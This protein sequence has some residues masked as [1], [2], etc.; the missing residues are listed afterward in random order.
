MRWR[1]LLPLAA[2]ATAAATATAGARRPSIKACCPALFVRAP[3]ISHRAFG[4]D[5][6]SSGKMSKRRPREPESAAAADKPQP[7]F[8]PALP[9]VERM[10]VLRAQAR[11]EQDDGEGAPAGSEQ[12]SRQHE[13]VVLA[14]LKELVIGLK[15]CPWAAPALNAGA[16]RI[17]IHGG[18]DEDLEA[19]TKL[20]LEEAMALAGM[21]E[22]G[23]RNAT[24]LIGVPNALSDFDAFLEYA[25]VIDDL[26]DELGLRGKVQLASFHPNY[27]FADSTPETEE[28]DYT[29]RAPIPLLHLLREVELSRALHQYPGDPDGIWR[30]NKVGGGDVVV[31]A[32]LQFCASTTRHPHL[33]SPPPNPNPNPHQGGDA[34]DGEAAAAGPRGRLQRGGGCS[35][36]RRWWRVAA[37]KIGGIPKCEN[38]KSIETQMLALFV[39]RLFAF[40]LRSPDGRAHPPRFLGAAFL[41]FIRDSQTKSNTQICPLIRLHIAL[42][43]N[44]CRTPSLLLPHHP[45]IT[46]QNP[47]HPRSR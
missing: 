26:I 40:S 44:T 18:D 11:A 38:E 29:N 2:A 15:L 7:S 1:P 17:R 14:W 9:T 20:L 12:P 22:A 39:L 30:R 35:S 24:V 47:T 34:R 32:C 8:P 31:G 19:L 33:T 28:E 27:R 6:G 16:I 43:N 41:P 46:A 5:A 13:A 3:R 25:A 4:V 23:G 36:R 21:P 42:L 45:F 10:R 37:V